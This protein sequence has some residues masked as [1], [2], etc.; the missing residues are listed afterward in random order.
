MATNC[1]GLNCR[2]HNLFFSNQ[3]MR[4]MDQPHVNGLVQKRPMSSANALELHLFCINTLWPSDTI[5]RHR[6]GS[7]LAQIMACCL[8]APSHYLN[9]CWLI[10]SKSHW[11]LGD[12]H[13]TKDTS[14]T[15]LLKL[16]WKLLIYNF[17]QI[18][19]GPMSLAIHVVWK[20]LQ[21]CRQC[22]Q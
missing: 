14:V 19:Q 8:T 1:S 6:T 22:D 15:N 4:S 12:R 3:S 18:S 16:A 10:I 5:W 17:L 20:K 9:Q 7:T 11:H 2:Q 13:F 21:A